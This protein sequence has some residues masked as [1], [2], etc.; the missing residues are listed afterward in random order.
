[1][2]MNPSPQLAPSHTIAFKDSRQLHAR[3]VFS[4]HLLV[5][6]EIKKAVAVSRIRVKDLFVES[7]TSILI[8]PAC[9]FGSR[10]AVIG[11]FSLPPPPPPLV[12]SCRA[13]HHPP[14]LIPSLSFS[15]NRPSATG[16][17]FPSIVLRTSPPPN[18]TPTLNQ[19]PPY[20]PLNSHQETPPPTP[21]I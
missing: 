12:R 8:P 21:Q 1:M 3:C 19:P 13:I 14:V 9:V 10:T 17:A 6:L 7:L 18:I 16:R 5:Y 11:M 20:P 2:Y 4:L 15:A